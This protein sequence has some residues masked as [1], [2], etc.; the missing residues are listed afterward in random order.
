MMRKITILAG[1]VVLIGLSGAAAWR[2]FGPSAEL[3]VTAR[4]G[5]LLPLTGS[6]SAFGQASLIGVELAIREVNDAGGVLNGRLEL[7]T[8]DT[9]TNPQAGVM[10]AQSLTNIDGVSGIVGAMASSVTIPVAQSVAKFTG[11]SLISP[12]STSP[13]LSDLADDDFLFRTTPH[14]EIQGKLLAQLAEDQG[15]ETVAILFRN[16]DYG[17]S[18]AEIFSLNFD[19]IVTAIVGYEPGQPIYTAEIEQAAIGGISDTLVLISHLEEGIP[20]L[21]KSIDGSYFKNFIF[22]DG[23]KANEVVQAIGQEYL[24]TS[25][26]TAPEGSDSEN[27]ALYKNQY[28]IA[29][30]EFPEDQPFVGNAYDAAI[31]LALAIESAGSAEPSAVRNALRVVA[32]PPGEIV[33]P[34]EFARAKELIAA[35]ADINYEGAAGRQN[36]DNAGDV[37]GS[38]AHWVFRNGSIEIVKIIGN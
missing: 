5:G 25:F 16:D 29:Y 17:R 8:A 37:D 32:N 26:G 1:V 21:Q 33:R 23:M 13:I 10:A 20:I 15:V 14:D 18:L 9:E 11:V 7:V 4:I 22:A 12:S 36:F 30:G 38:F 31:L 27:Y 19:G 2:F 3:P 28:E 35:G 34:S 6:L 24:E